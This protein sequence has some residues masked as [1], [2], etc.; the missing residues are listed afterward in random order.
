MQTVTT[1]TVTRR[2]A[3]LPASMDY[4]KAR[5]PALGALRKLDPTAWR[6]VVRAA[7]KEHGSVPDAA[8]ALE[9]STRTLFRWISESKGDLTKGI[10]TR[11]AGR[12]WPK[13]NE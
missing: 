4:S 9:V 5:G 3:T 6:D 12:P 8:G 2:R 11:G 7:L 1:G 13:G 10:E